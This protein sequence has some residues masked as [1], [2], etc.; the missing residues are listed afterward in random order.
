MP[1]VGSGTELKA[2]CSHLQP[3]ISEF[4]LK[5]IIYGP[6]ETIPETRH[7]K[8]YIV[9]KYKELKVHVETVKD[10]NVDVI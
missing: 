3:S 5:D 2:T 1:K 6:L 8:T 4:S 10:I 9:P 7:S